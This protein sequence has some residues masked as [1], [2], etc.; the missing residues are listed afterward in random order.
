MIIIGTV[1]FFQ[2]K[3]L[4]LPHKITMA[5]NMLLEIPGTITKSMAVITVGVRF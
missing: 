3:L 1:F 4:N 5:G 2:E